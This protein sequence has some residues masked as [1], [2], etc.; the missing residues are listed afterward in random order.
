MTFIGL[1]GKEGGGNESEVCEREELRRED[2]EGGEEKQ[3]RLTGNKKLVRWTKV[4]RQGNERRNLEAVWGWR[5]GGVG[6]GE[7]H[8]ESKQSAAIKKNE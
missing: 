3:K 8:C 1:L 6:G 4:R 2:R 7:F 5:V